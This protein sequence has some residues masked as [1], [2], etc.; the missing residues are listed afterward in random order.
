MNTNLKRGKRLLQTLCSALAADPH[1]AGRSWD[2]DEIDTLLDDWGFG[3]GIHLTDGTYLRDHPLYPDI[4]MT[5][6]RRQNPVGTQKLQ[7]AVGCIDML[8]TRGFT[9]SEEET[10]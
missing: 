10:G 6:P 4:H 5:I 8:I 7:E 1:K 3:Q 9:T 2:A